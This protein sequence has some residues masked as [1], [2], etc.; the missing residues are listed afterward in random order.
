MS[1]KEKVLEILLSSNDST[2]G[3]DM[4]E[5]LG[6]SRNSIWKA[7]NSLKKEGYKIEA[8]TNKG[9]KIVEKSDMISEVLIKKHLDHEF[10]FIKVIVE[11]EVTSTI[12][13]L[14]ELA[15]KGEPE[16]TV[17]IA[18]RQTAGKGRQGRSFFSPK[19]MGLYLSILLRPKFTAEQSLFITTAAAV[20]TAKAIEAVSDKKAEIKWVNDVYVDNKKV[21]GILTEASI[22]FESGGLQYAVLGIGVNVKEPEGGFPDELKDIATALYKGDPP[23]QTRSK[24]AAEII[25]SFFEFYQNLE[26][27]A[28]MQEYRE[29]SFL[30][31]RDIVFTMGNQSTSGTVIGI[32]DDARLV[33]RLEDGTEERYMTGEVSLVKNWRN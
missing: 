21:C 28:F 30:T 25:S 2:S 27:K 3:E 14:K 16:G 10:D 7:V 20:A 13:V 23:E 18:Q 9:Y 6:V 24:L 8:V 19:N 1:V 26:D 32:D 22:D 17:L 33:V 11:H 4:A 31:G 29:R 12:T 15:E 5:K